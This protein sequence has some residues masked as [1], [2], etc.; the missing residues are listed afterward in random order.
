LSEFLSHKVHMTESVRGQH[1]MRCQG[2]IVI[3]Y[4]LIGWF[5][6]TAPDVIGTNIEAL[7]HGGWIVNWGIIH[8][9]G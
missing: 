1:R 7:L 9:K 5:I 6:S 2:L 8:R 4:L 3:D